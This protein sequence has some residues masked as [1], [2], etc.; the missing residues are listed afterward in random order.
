MTTLIHKRVAMANE[1]TNPYVITRLKS[2][3]VVI[4]DVQPIEGYC[5]LLADPVVKDLNSLNEAGVLCCWN[6][7][8]HRLI[9]IL[10][11]G[12]GVEV[13]SLFR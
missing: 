11:Y 1:G 13:L 8:F 9:C 6:R 5:L 3:W 12:S 7:G 10:R 2:G 4:G